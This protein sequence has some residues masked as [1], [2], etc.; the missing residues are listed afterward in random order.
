VVITTPN[1]EYNQL[2]PSLPAGRFR[3]PDHRFEWS[4]KEFQ[5]WGQGVAGAHGY[6]VDFGAIGEVDGKLGGPTQMAVFKR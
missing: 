5:D 6:E 1:A 3:H 4:R 2:F